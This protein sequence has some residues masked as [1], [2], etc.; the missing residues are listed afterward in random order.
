MTHISEQRFFFRTRKQE[1]NSME[2]ATRSNMSYMDKLSKFHRQQGTPLLKP[3]AIDKQ[4][5]DLYLLKR[6]VDA[7]GSFK[8]VCAH[9]KWAEI[10]REL[11]FG[12]TKNVTSVSSALKNAYQKY[13]L[14]YEMYLEKAKPEFLREMGITPSP[15][16]E[17][18]MDS[19]KTTSVGMRRNLL[20]ELH[21]AE[22]PSADGRMSDVD[23]VKRIVK[24]ETPDLPED[25]KEV[26]PSPSQR[27]L[28]RPF[29]ETITKRS[30][31]IST[32]NDREDQ[33]VR[34]ESK[35][36]KACNVPLN[37]PMAH[38]SFRT[39]GRR[40]KY[41]SACSFK[42]LENGWDAR[43]ALISLQQKTWRKL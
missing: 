40:L 36:L 26:T 17:K 7:R 25:M 28:K 22:T 8:D 15:Q 16:Q 37:N 43:D 38:D 3:P 27:G 4:P 1:L 6:A 18:K 20:A 41:G 12:S 33:P 19:L 23:E 13:L 5:I 42:A 32:E 21:K 11:G 35:R 14:P 39:D 30:A 2:G 24:S 29:E 10:G 31:S 34:R 9:K